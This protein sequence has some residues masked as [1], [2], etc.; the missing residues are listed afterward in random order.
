[1]SHLSTIRTVIKDLDALKAACVDLGFTFLEGKKTFSWFGKFMNDWND[2]RSAVAQ[3]F[4]PATFGQCEHA[5][6]VPG[7]TYELGVVR[8]D[9]GWRL[10]MDEWGPGRTIVEQA[11]PGCGL[12]AQAYV[13]RAVQ[14]VMRGMETKG[15][16][17]AGLVGRVGVPGQAVVLTFQRG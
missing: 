3:G 1:M 9:D 7:S 16:R 6:S 2:E 10:L 11:G 17:P 4:D 12:L 5:I 15:F 14:N 13:V 8:T